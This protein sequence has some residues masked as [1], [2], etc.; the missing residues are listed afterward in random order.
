MRLPDDSPALSWGLALSGGADSTALLHRCCGAGLAITA[1]HFNHGF[2]DENG[3]EAEAFC[4]ALCVS[5]NVPLRV[6]RC[7]E[8][9]TG[10]ATKEVFARRHRMAFFADASRALGLEGI[11]L[12]HQA[13]DRAE[14]L[15]LRLARGC[16]LGG[17]TS[18]G[19]AGRLPGAP[20]VRLWRPL[21]D[22]THADQVAWLRARGLAWVEDVS[23]AD[24]SIPRNAIRRHVIPSLPHFVAGANASADLLAEEDAFLE[25]L[26]QQATQA[27]SPERLVLAPDTPEVLARRAL[28]AWLPGLTRA[29]L[30]RLF[31]LR[32]G[33]IVQV[34]GGLRI[35]KTAPFVWEIAAGRPRR[36]ATR[37]VSCEV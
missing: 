18:F 24:T 35:R 27:V 30:G 21:L 4:R 33:V 16:G 23:N 20:E 25:G 31:E 32:V 13:D 8:S 26:T 34:P 22:E 28:R 15:I 37:V 10:Q 6:G 9:W 2:A 12:G 14:N 17:L 19:W 29:W 36:L 1:L 5:L 3:N 11:L 7:A